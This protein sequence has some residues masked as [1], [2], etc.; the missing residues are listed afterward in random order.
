LCINGL[1]TNLVGLIA[2]VGLLVPLGLS[3]HLSSL[4][5]ERLQLIL[6]KAGSNVRQYYYD[7]KL[8]GVDW[9]AK[10]REAKEKIAKAT[11]MDTAIL[12]IDE[13]LESLNDPHTFFVPP[14]YSI[15]VD[16]GVRFQMV[17][18]RCYVTHVRPQS[19]AETKGLKPGDEVLAINGVTTTRESLHKIEYV[20]NV[21]L[22]L[23]GLHVD[24]WDHSDKKRRVEVAANVHHPKLATPLGEELTGLDTWQLNFEAEKWVRPLRTH[25]QELG[26]DLMILK[27][28][29]F[30]SPDELYMQEKIDKAR[31]HNALILDLRGNG[32]GVPDNL[33]YLLGG[34]FEKDVKIADRVS[35]DTTTPL[36]A[37][38]N[39]H[40]VFTGKL[41]VLV[42]SR[43]G[44]AAEL[45]ARTIQIE[46]RGTIL[47]DRTAGWV[48]E[49]RPYGSVWVTMTDLV[50]AD[51]KSLEHVGVTPDETILPSAA[52]LAN[53]RD[54]VLARAAQL[55]GVDLSPEKAA[56]VVPVR[57]AEELGNLSHELYRSNPNTPTP[58]VVPTYTLP[59]VI[60][61]VMNLFPSPN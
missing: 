15:W 31:R 44:G 11:S 39:H 38:S 10:V 2:T 34:L 33:Q 21:L 18:E 6:Q 24:V 7:P 22:P 41:I 16:Y 19:D 51:G 26:I 43:S 45:L 40:H 58:L 60:I 47:G 35:R 48:M 4:D 27:I 36:T 54:P 25:Y 28:P 13:V 1:L 14:R 30:F 3:Q 5:R 53:G 9:D 56:P 37:K 49:S 42:D 29:V 57:M 20:L 23:S 55:A 52:D 8:H 61:G 32:G 46:K 17:G 59:F 12:Q 50:M